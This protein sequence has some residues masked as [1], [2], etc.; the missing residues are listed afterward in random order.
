MYVLQAPHNW[1]LGSMVAQGCHIVSKVLWELRE[2]ENVIKYMSDIDNMH[3]VTLGAKDEAELTGLEEQLKEA[4]VECRAWRE[5]P[6]NVI[7]ALVISSQPPAYAR[8]PHYLR[9]RIK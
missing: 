5:Q 4:G 7:T 3:K 2:E 8:L 6:E 1:N 9:T